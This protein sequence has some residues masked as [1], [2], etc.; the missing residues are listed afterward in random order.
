MPACDIL[1]EQLRQKALQELAAV[2]KNKDSLLKKS[3]NMLIMVCA[4]ARVDG[5][6]KYAQRYWDVLS[7]WAHYLRAKGLDPENQ[8]FMPTVAEDVSFGP[9]YMGLPDNEVREA[10]DGALRAVDMAGFSKRVSHHL[11]FGEKKRIAVA[12]VLS[13]SPPH[14][15]AG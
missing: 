15:G 2:E 7:K 13:M 1:A 6:A 4:M 9:L 14:P 12:T 8:L 3:G 5:N 10:V 11:S